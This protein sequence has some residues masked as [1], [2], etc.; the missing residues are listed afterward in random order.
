MSRQILS[1]PALVE[2]A[3]TTIV[4]D[5]AIKHDVLNGAGQAAAERAIAAFKEDVVHFA[6]EVSGR[7]VIFY[8]PDAVINHSPQVVVE[9]WQFKDGSSIALVGLSVDGHLPYSL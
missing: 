2:K 5:G 3:Y 9:L 8:S 6:V 1:P 7:D 4:A